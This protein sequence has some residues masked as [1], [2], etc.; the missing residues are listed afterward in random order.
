[1]ACWTNMLCRPWTGPRQWNQHPWVWPLAWDRYKGSLW[2]HKRPNPEL[3]I[4][5]LQDKQRM[6]RMDFYN[7]IEFADEICKLLL[8][9]VRVQWLRLEGPVRKKQK[10]RRHKNL[11]RLNV[12][13]FQFIL[14]CL[15]L[16]LPNVDICPFFMGQ[17]AGA[18]T[19]DESHLVTDV[20][21][22]WLLH[23]N[24]KLAGINAS[25]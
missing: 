15:V 2:H 8:V 13:S 21:L 18:K 25:A 16:L 20:P 17:P 9:K 23:C 10:F 3:S 6:C 19:S 5:I 14:R 11:L 1:M 12:Y 4:L 7:S 24:E 22:Q